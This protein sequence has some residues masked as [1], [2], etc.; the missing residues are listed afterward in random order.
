M[1]AA[2][3]LEHGRLDEARAAAERDVDARPDDAEAHGL[4][5]RLLARLGELAAA[6]AALERAT[7]LAP[8]R[9]QHAANWAG[10]LR[11]LARLEPARSALS[12]A[13]ALAPERAELHVNRGNIETSADD[14]EAAIAWFRHALSLR[15]DLVGA[16][17]SL[18]QALRRRGRSSQAQGPLEAAVVRQP[19]AG[20]A[21]SMLA[22]VLLDQGKAERALKVASDGLVRC[23]TDGVLLLNRGIALTELGRLDEALEAL[24]ESQRI[25]PDHVEG[26]HRLSLVHRRLG[27]VQSAIAAQWRAAVLRPGSPRTWRVIGSLLRMHRR[28]EE[29]A[30][31]FGVA[32]ELQPGHVA[33]LGNLGVV[34]EGLG[35]ASEALVRFQSAHRLAP[36]MAIVCDRIGSWHH[37]RKNWRDAEEWYRRAIVLE[38]NFTDSH[39]NLGLTARRQGRSAKAVLHFENAVAFSPEQP[40]YR[41]DRALAFLTS[42]R[43]REGLRD[44]HWRWRSDAMATVRHMMRDPVFRQPEWTGELLGGRSLAVWGEQGLGDELWFSGFLDA[45]HGIGGQVEVECDPRLA[46]VLTRSYPRHR[47]HERTAPPADELLACAMQAAMGD[48]AMRLG[49]AE[50][51]APTGYLVADAA[52][53][54]DLRRRYLGGRSDALVGI[55]WRSTKPKVERSFEAPLSVWQPV[56]AL[57]GITFVNLQYGTVGAEL[58]E[59]VERSGTRII[60]DDDIN[61]REDI[62]GLVAQVAAM[63]AVV[64]VA[65]ATAAAAHGVGRPS[66]VAL[67]LDQDDWRYPEAASVTPW[68]PLARLYWQVKQDEWDAVFIRIARDLERWRLDWRMQS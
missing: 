55:S 1:T 39:Y 59:A 46:S 36:N 28:A 30:R 57:D 38:P 33:T 50:R 9:A 6:A 43:A 66:F 47:I 21:W 23:P 37:K 58:A 49:F 40:G 52:R 7:R 3:L 12:R 63:D 32:L 10:V 60:A 26:A 16:A 24:A 45:L 64:T 56:L 27:D 14:D 51:S 4:L 62:E 18:A 54:G 13:L 61:A 17:V 44:Y 2:G 11:R 19:E 41:Y 34:L 5:G 65:N 42:G 35:L 15:A 29:A 68:L 53:V 8:E 20:E 25:L 31:A 48:L 22:A 67:R